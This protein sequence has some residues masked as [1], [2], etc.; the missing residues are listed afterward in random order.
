MTVIAKDGR[1]VSAGVGSCTWSRKFIEMSG[2]EEAE[3]VRSIERYLK[4]VEVDI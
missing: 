3:L 4:D 2:T 1:V